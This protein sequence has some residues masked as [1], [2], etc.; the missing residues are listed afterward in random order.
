M[1]TIRV[2]FFI[3]LFILGVYYVYNFLPSQMELTTDGLPN[4]GVDWKYSFRPATLSILA[5]HS[6]YTDSGFYN[7]PW[8][9]LPLIPIALLSAP[10]GSAVI[11]VLNL[12]GY[13]FSALKMRMNAIMFVLFSLF[14]GVLLNSWNGNVEGLVVLGFILPPQIGLFFVL[15][16]PQFGI[17]VATFWIVE[18][19]LQGGIRRVVRVVAPASVAV[20]L[21][22]VMFGF[23]P[24]R[25]PNLAGVWW[26]SSIFPYGIPIG[27][28]LLGIA[29]WRQDIRF[30]IASSPF[31]APYVTLHTW[32]VVW[33]G[34]LLLVPENLA[35]Y[36]ELRK[37]A[38]A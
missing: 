34:I 16:K 6:P 26:D 37:N 35:A 8:L 32:A 31:F 27:L 11:F 33:F 28:I 12:Y 30:A 25:S 7:P 24:A 38:P 9:L 22:F 2:L 4:I 18:A 20:I 17:G 21:S 1:K 19:C 3:A 5:G 10:L 13:F 14:S 23:W 15:C 36:R 29:I